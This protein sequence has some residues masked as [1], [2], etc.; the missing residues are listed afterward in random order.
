MQITITK[1]EIKKKKKRK[2]RKG[3]KK[4]QRTRI[5]YPFPRLPKSIDSLG[6]Q[7]SANLAT[8]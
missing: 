4:N 1:K 2:E 5:E 6:F 7:N 8:I 3:K